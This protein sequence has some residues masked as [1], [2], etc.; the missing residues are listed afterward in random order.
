[1]NN[2]NTQHTNVKMLVSISLMAALVCAVAL[3][4]SIPT[5]V[6][7][8]TMQLFGVFLAPLLLGLR[9]TA[10]VGIYIL[11]GAAGA[12]VFAEYRGG[13]SI[14]LGPTGGYIIGFFAASL[15]IGLVRSK[16][17]S[18]PVLFAVTLLSLVPLYTC[19]VLQL[20]YVLDKSLYEAFLIGVPSF[21]LIDCIKA[22][23]SVVLAHALSK[24]LEKVLIL[25]R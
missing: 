8:I 20:A 12:P 15:L 17:R 7:P 25:T 4:P 19:G 24:R 22:A 1:M 9:G 14:I 21:I 16:T 3:I 5:P 23:T 6:V 18:F 13:M 2:T 11:I 10:A